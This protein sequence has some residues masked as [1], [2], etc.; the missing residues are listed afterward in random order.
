MA[1]VDRLPH[2][3]AMLTGHGGEFGG[4]VNGTI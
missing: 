2:A 4:G 3:L 1:T